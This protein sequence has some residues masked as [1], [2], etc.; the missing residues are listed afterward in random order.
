MSFNYLF[1]SDEN[2]KQV[3]LIKGAEEGPIPSA[4]L[5]VTQKPYVSVISTILVERL[6]T[7]GEDGKQVANISLKIMS[8]IWSQDITIIIFLV[9][10]TPRNKDTIK[11]YFILRKTNMEMMSILEGAQKIISDEHVDIELITGIDTEANEVKIESM[12]IEHLAEF[13]IVNDVNGDFGG[14]FPQIKLTFTSF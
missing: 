8:H 11:G 9:E 13:M 12:A 10:V 6:N 2:K 5:S 7:I 1:N 3:K 4:R 14:S